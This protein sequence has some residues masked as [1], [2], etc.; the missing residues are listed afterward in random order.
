[1][2]G[3]RRQSEKKGES[4]AKEGRGGGGGGVH[5]SKASR[6]ESLSLIGCFAI[7]KLSNEDKL[8]LYN[9]QTLK[10]LG[11]KKRESGDFPACGVVFTSACM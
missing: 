6:T 10:G 1:M 9:D 2:F 11:G 3:G 5:C 8:V 4:R 7:R